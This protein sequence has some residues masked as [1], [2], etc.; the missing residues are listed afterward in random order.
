MAV[1]FNE[2]TYDFL[3][4]IKIFYPFWGC[5]LRIPCATS[6]E[7][8]PKR[9]KLNS[10]QTKVYLQPGLA[11]TAKSHSSRNGFTLSG[12]VS[13]LLQRALGRKSASRKNLR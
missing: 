11:K 2:T 9:S 1:F 12:W 3:L 7:P 6:M 8:M 5:E 10:R 4:K 13:L